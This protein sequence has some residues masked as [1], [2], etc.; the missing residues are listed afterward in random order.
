MIEDAVANRDQIIG[1]MPAHDKQFNG[2]LARLGTEQFVAYCNTNPKLKKCR[3]GKVLTMSKP[4]NLIIVHRY[5]PLSDGR[6]RVR[7]IPTYTVSGG[8]V[9]GEGEVPAKENV[10]AQQ[11][12]SIVELHDGVVSHAVSRKLD[13]AGWR[14]D[15]SGLTLTDELRREPDLAMFTQLEEWMIAS[16]GVPIDKSV[17]FSASCDLQKWIVNGTVDFV[18]VFCGTRGLTFAVRNIGLEAGE[19]F[20]RQLATYGRRWDIEDSADQYLLYWMI[21]SGLRP[22]AI[23]IATPCLSIFSEDEGVRKIGTELCVQITEDLCEYQASQGFLASVEQPAE[24]KMFCSES[25][26]KLFGGSRSPINGWD[27][28]VCS[29]CRHRLTMVNERDQPV[30]IARRQIWMSNFSLKPLA[31]ECKTLNYCTLE[32]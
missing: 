14:Y 32:Q 11:I 20:D 2:K 27:Y 17:T 8:E 7:W 9:L 15:E 18:E 5:S 16:K 21:S 31:L 19:G 6:L 13:N 26:I 3:I 23:H 29:A 4:E 28:L 12:V 30:P 1:P 10:R 24:S 25:W 22:Y